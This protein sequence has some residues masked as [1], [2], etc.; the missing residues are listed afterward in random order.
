VV[1]MTPVGNLHAE[2]FGDITVVTRHYRAGMASTDYK[3]SIAELKKARD[4]ELITYDLRAKSPLIGYIR[5]VNRP[6]VHVLDLEKRLEEMRFGFGNEDFV[7]Y[8]HFNDRSHRLLADVIYD[9]LK[10]N[11]LLGRTRALQNTR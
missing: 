1:L 3:Q 10:K 8:F 5:K 2:P 9:F 6:N 4:A 11:G 7:D